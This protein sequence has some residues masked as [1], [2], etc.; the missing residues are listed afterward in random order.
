[1]QKP[2]P[3]RNRGRKNGRRRGLP[4]AVS[5]LVFAV[6]VFRAGPSLHRTSSRGRRCPGPRRL[7][8][9]SVVPGAVVRD[10]A[11]RPPRSGE[12][13]ERCGQE[14]ERRLVPPSAPWLLTTPPGH[15][16][17]SAVDAHRPTVAVPP[18]D[19]VPRSRCPAERNA[20]LPARRR[21]RRGGSVAEGAHEH[22]LP[23]PLGTG[24]AR[25]DAGTQLAG[26]GQFPQELGA[27]PPAL[28]SALLS[29]GALAV[30]ALS[31]GRVLARPPRLRRARPGSRQTPRR[32]FLRHR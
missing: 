18:A 23:Q 28:R 32:A 30:R 16:A 27:P 1:M 14:G 26:L 25:L 24:A 3:Y 31:S 8:V 20:R 11:V 21:E 6:S 29:S 5:A 2:R 4:T 17:S 12:T 7:R 9:P 19:P 13:G 10:G 22:R 15:A